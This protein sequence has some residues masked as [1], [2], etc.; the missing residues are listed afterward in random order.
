MRSLDLTS[1]CWRPQPL[2]PTDAQPVPSTPTSPPFALSV[3]AQ[4]RSRRVGLAG[5]F[6]FA[7]SALRS[8]RTVL[9]IPSRLGVQ[10]VGWGE[11][12]RS[13]TQRH[14][15]VGHRYAHTHLLGW[16]EHSAGAW[17]FEG[18][19]NPHPSLR[20]TFSRGEKGSLSASPFALSVAAQRRSRRVGLAA[21][22]DF[23]LSALRS[24]RVAGVNTQ[25]PAG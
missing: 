17:R 5:D 18:W 12:Q 23:A 16:F 10:S 2:I 9:V 24:A 1:S 8:A 25:G 3:A 11:R 19:P 6:D 21:G 7:P 4:R 20:A 15:D 13:P 22:F 14:G